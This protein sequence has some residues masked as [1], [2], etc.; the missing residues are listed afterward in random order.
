[1]KLSTAFLTVMMLFSTSSFAA[2]EIVCKNEGFSDLTVSLTPGGTFVNLTVVA[3]DSRTSFSP[4]AGE[5]AIL[6][7][8]KGA[9]SNDWRVLRS[10]SSS[11]N[12]NIEMSL[13]KELKKTFKASFRSSEAFMT[14]T[15]SNWEM[16][17]VLK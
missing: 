6:K 16:T 5:T 13:P 9:V 2:S 7:V 11:G 14:S 10:E 4:N 17:C 15:L 8:D 12:R 3:A 1:M